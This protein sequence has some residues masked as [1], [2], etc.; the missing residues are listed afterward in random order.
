MKQPTRLYKQY[1]SGYH[2]GIR[3]VSQAAES[4]HMDIQM[5]SR[6]MQHLSAS[7]PLKHESSSQ[8]GSPPSSPESHIQ[9]FWSPPSSPPQIHPGFRVASGMTHPESQ[10]YVQTTMPTI[11]YPQHHITSSSQSGQSSL[12]NGHASSFSAGLLQRI[13]SQSSANPS[14]GPQGHSNVRSGPQLV[15]ENN[16][17]ISQA[18]LTTT[19]LWRPW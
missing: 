16:N 9:R 11:R 7:Q 10:L 3:T 15:D 1:S 19:T 12:S 5:R 2:E 14:Q 4:A 8:S 18:V 13:P 6:L 17:T